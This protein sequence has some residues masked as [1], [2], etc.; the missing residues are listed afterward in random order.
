MVE[1]EFYAGDL[2]ETF[3]RHAGTDTLRAALAGFLD[4]AKADVWRRFETTANQTGLDHAARREARQRLSDGER[5]PPGRNPFLEIEHALDQIAR[6]E[7][8]ARDPDVIAKVTAKQLFAVYRPRKSLEIVPLPD[9]E[10]P[11]Y[12]ASIADPDTFKFR[13]DTTFTIIADREGEGVRL[14][15]FSES[16]A[17]HALG[18]RFAD[19][20]A[21]KAAALRDYGIAE[22]DWRAG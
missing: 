5:A 18:R 3:G 16:A 21:A 13:R 9:I 15:V 12:R 19:T 10:D 1:T 2:L 11:D 7:D 20:V 14:L 8:G 22:T 4:R 17:D 6:I